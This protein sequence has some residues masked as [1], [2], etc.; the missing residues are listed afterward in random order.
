MS[1]ATSVVISPSRALN[2]LLLLIVGCACV[3]LLCVLYWY[4]PRANLLVASLGSVV[5]FLML[6]FVIRA[7]L[8]ALRQTIRYGLNVDS[9]GDVI[10]RRLDVSGRVHESESVELRSPL[11]LWR[12]VLLLSLQNES[13]KVKRLLILRDSV[14][15]AGFR[16]LSLAFHW[17]VQAQ[18]NTSVQNDLSEGNF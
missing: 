1:I 10:L 16:R 15:D 8:N 14:S 9:N 13:G 12:S 5:A 2:W 6:Y 4:L 17:L 18:T 3:A 7:V 11:I